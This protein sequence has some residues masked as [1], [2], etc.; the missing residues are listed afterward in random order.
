MRVIGT[1][2]WSES[3]IAGRCDDVLL[4]EYQLGREMNAYE[5]DSGAIKKSDVLEFN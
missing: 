2:L 5:K 3:T 4:Q 1:L